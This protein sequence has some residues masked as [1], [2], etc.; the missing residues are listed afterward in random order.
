M[1]YFLALFVQNHVGEVVVFVD[2]QV[3]R[4][5]EA[6]RIIYYEFQLTG[7]GRYVKYSLDHISW[8]IVPITTHKIVKR[9]CAILF[10]IFLKRAD[11]SPNL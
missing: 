7:I 1:I 8:I 5:L 2:Y 11:V 9:K 3:Q 4:N 10:E 6:F